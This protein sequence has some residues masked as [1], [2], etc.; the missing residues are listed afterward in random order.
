VTARLKVTPVA[1][2]LGGLVL[3]ALAVALSLLPAALTPNALQQTTNEAE[4]MFSVDR[5]LLLLP[6][7]CTRVRWDVSGIEA[8]Y[9]NDQGEIGSGDNAF[10][11]STTPS[12]AVLRV[13]FT[14][15]RTEV[16]SL[17]VFFLLGGPHQWIFL[18]AGGFC[19]LGSLLLISRAATIVTG[20]LMTVGVLIGGF[21]WLSPAA[22]SP[23]WLLWLHI[24][25]FGL[26]L[27]LA[28]LRPG[29]D[30]T[31]RLQRFGLIWLV[32]LP[33]ALFVSVTH[34]FSTSDVASLQQLSVRL[35]PLFYGLPLLGAMVVLSLP[36]RMLRPLLMNGVLVSGG[37]LIALALVEVST[38]IIASNAGTAP[39]I[40]EIQVPIFGQNR[41]TMRPNLTWEDQFYATDYTDEVSSVTYNTNDSGFRDADFV[42]DRTPG[43]NRVAM[44]G[45][46]FAMG[47]GVDAWETAATVIETELTNNH[48][49]PTEVYNYGVPGHNVLTYPGV[50]QGEVQPYNP[51]VVLIWYFLNDIGLSSGEFLEDTFDE[52]QQDY[53]PML[54]GRLRFV[55]AAANW[56][57][58]YA[59]AE[60][61]IQRFQAAYQNPDLWQDVTASLT[62]IADIAAETD[63]TPAIFV[64]PILYRLDENRYPYSEIHAQMIDFA[65]RQ[66]Y[67]TADLFNALAGNNHRDLWIHPADSHP[68]AVAHRL[69]GKYAAAQL[70]PLL[71]CGPSS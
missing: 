29:A 13:D 18:L 12:A 6:G 10:C 47:I 31:V 22:P 24:L 2:L 64:H 34:A 48:D 15:G 28:G 16:F 49:C 21:M 43:V 5:Q 23:F 55:D 70:A 33:A 56:L 11:P 52:Q 45:D 50:Y 37:V 41:I 42:L 35:I 4:V 38:R 27:L 20:G 25:I 17:P 51:D 61:G 44:I 7:Q 8:V 54:R 62:S 58:Q 69:A 39:P 68:N 19:L 26:A 67:A 60:L 9:V 30:A 57:Y 46:S 71:G 53:F 3:V 36:A 40:T 63:T 1:L 65:G 59:E 32:L 14:D 66:G